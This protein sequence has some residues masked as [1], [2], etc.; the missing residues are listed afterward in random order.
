PHTTASDAWQRSVQI[1]SNTDLN[2]AAEPRLK[3]T[4]QQDAPKANHPFFWAG[5]L[6]ADTGALPMTDEQEQAADQVLAAKA[7]ADIKAAAAKDK[8]AAVQE[9]R[10]GGQKK[11]DADPAEAGNNKKLAGNGGAEVQPP[12]DKTATD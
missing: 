12:E 3:L 4:A 7:A 11:D 9:L 2:A 1:V 6:L 10:P 8:M 5:Y